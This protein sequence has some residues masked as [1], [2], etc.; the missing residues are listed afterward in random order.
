MDFSKGG[1]FFSKGGSF[2]S[3]GGGFFSKGTG[4]LSAISA[5]APHP[6]SKYFFRFFFAVS[7]LLF[8][9]A[10][11]SVSMH[12]FIY[13]YQHTM[14]GKRY[15]V[16]EEENGSCMMAEEPA[17][18]YANMKES[19]LSEGKAFDYP[20][21]YDPG[22]GPYSMKELN[23][24]IDKAETDRMNPDKWIRVDDFWAEMQKIHLWLQ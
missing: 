9:F 16:I 15:P 17:V 13:N 14:E 20:S 6:A 10:A 12:T 4:F 22:I 23:A 1:S 21:D 18:S 24:R 5:E 3:K 19:C 11:C 8:I 2:F 7:K